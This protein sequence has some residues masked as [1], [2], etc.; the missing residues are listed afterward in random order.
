MS[1]NAAAFCTSMNTIERVGYGI[2]AV[3][4]SNIRGFGEQSNAELRNTRRHLLVTRRRNR[5]PGIVRC[6]SSH[7]IRASR[8]AARVIV[9]PK[10]HGE[11]AWEQGR[12][13][14]YMTRTFGQFS[15]RS[16]L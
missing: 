7:Y 14:T 15:R 3:G 16:R 11:V 5:L 9:C 8:L 12:G 2:A 1:Y 6:M 4:I 13:G 10:S